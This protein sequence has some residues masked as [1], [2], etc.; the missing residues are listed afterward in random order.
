LAPPAITSLLPIIPENDP[1]RPGWF[2]KPGSGGRTECTD[3]CILSAEEKSAFRVCEPIREKNTNNK[4]PF[5]LNWFYSDE[6][7]FS[8]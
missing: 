6:L 7:F 5:I 2:S 8:W 4:K 3:H 1:A